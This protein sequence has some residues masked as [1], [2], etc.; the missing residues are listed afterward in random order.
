[1]KKIIGLVLCIVLILSLNIP[2]KAEE[3]SLNDYFVQL[4]F[5]T[6]QTGESFLAEIY[7]DKPYEYSIQIDSDG[8]F[9]INDVQQGFSLQE[10]D[11][12]QYFE[13]M[14]K[15]NEGDMTVNGYSE[16]KVAVWK[17]LSELRDSCPEEYKTVS[18]N[19][20]SVSQGSG[21]W[22]YLQLGICSIGTD[23]ANDPKYLMVALLHEA[24]HIKDYKEKEYL[25]TEEYENSAYPITHNFM[26]KLK[27]DTGWYD[28]QYQNKYWQN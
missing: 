21:N 15:D 20:I 28:N 12:L 13:R 23:T 5:E 3:V 1:M 19:L 16:F 7:K 24:T 4:G 18:E 17:A 26:V 22:G 9:F 27:Y 25:T 11:R 14:F 2:V 8:S 6:Q 10:C